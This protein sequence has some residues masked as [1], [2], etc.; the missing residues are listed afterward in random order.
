MR[1]VAFPIRLGLVKVKSLIPDISLPP[2]FEKRLLNEIGVENIRAEL[3]ATLNA[4]PVAQ[5]KPR[6]RT[7]ARRTPPDRWQ[8]YTGLISKAARKAGDN[9][10]LFC[11]LLDAAHVP[12]PLRWSVKKWR[13]AYQKRELQPA[14][15]CFKSRH[16]R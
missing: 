5:P 8:Q 13:L 16:K 3:R 1:P 6:R 12:V 11:K 2:D 15:R 14:I 4:G 10:L 7:A 9:N